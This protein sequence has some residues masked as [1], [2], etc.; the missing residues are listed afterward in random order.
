MLGK[1]RGMEERKVGEWEESAKQGEAR[2]K[3]SP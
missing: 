2:A 3:V 1:D